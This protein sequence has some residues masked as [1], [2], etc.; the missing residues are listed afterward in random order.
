VTSNTVDVNVSDAVITAIQV[1]PSPVDIAKGQSQQLVAMATYN[2]TAPSDISSSVTWTLDDTN[3]A[4]VSEAGVLS[5]VEMGSTTLTAAKDGVTSNTVD[6]NVSAAVIIAIQVTPS[7]VDIAKGQ[8]QQLVAMATYSDTTSSDISSSVTWTP[9]DTNTATVTEAGLLSGV[10][11]GSTILTAT[12]DGVTS[13]TVN[14]NVSHAVITAI[15]V[16]PSPVDI[17]K[18]QSQQLVARATYS[19]TT[20]SDISS[21]VTWTSDDTNTATVTDAGVLSG[22]EV[23]STILTA[24]KDSVTSNTVDVDVCANLAGACIDIFDTGSG[25]LFTNSPSVAYLDSIGGSVTDGTKIEDGT[26]GPAGSFYKFNWV[27]AQSLCATYNTEIIG[28]RNNWRLATRDELKVEL[29]DAYNNMFA[30]RGWPTTDYYWS[31]TQSGSDYYSV[32]LYDGSVYSYIP[33]LTYY[34]SCVSEP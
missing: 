11:V 8:S 30:A 14:V 18:G 27:N 12:K 3:T 13:I 19:D 31:V 16:T 28:G 1:T 32:R 5:G 23:G 26:Y 2:N 22:V 20:S 21:S 34:A 4:T 24:T 17:A 6:V 10:E 7:P 9:D 25:K 15:Q 33:D 29:Y